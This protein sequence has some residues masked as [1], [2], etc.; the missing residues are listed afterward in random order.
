METIFG[1]FE[2]GK[3]VANG[4][5]LFEDWN[6]CRRVAEKWP[7]N[8][9]IEL[10]GAAAMAREKEE[11]RGERKWAWNGLGVFWLI[12]CLAEIFANKII[13]FALTMGK[14]NHGNEFD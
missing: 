6:P 1:G 7:A 5:R 2:D 14:F 9:L 8:T 11:R 12:K 3:M 10:G 13:L 4:A